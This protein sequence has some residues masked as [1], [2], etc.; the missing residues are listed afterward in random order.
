MTNIRIFKLVDGVLE[1]DREEITLYK[2]LRKILTR[3]KGSPGDSDGR[4][5]AQ[6]FKELRYIYFICD[7]SGH[8]RV[9][10]YSPKEAHAY[11]IEQCDLPL[12][13]VPDKDIQAAMDEYIDLTTSVAKELVDELLSVLRNNIRV[14]RILRNKID[15]SII[16]IEKADI[17][18][19]A[20]TTKLFT[21]Q[22][23]LIAMAMSIPSAIETLNKADAL[24]VRELH[25]KDGVMYGGD[26]IEDSMNP[27]QTL[28]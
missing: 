1:L 10:G 24:I 16:K 23:D 12:S 17:V 25:N 4:K 14:V 5:K 21:A 11:A 8:P 9:H 22:K 19:D 3:D 15:A 28:K 6:A 13:F 20:D 2:H 7:Y 27:D 18:E 26:T